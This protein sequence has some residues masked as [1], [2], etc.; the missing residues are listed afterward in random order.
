VIQPAA[1]E[2]PVSDATV[3]HSA[4]RLSRGAWWGLGF[5]WAL[6]LVALFMAVTLSQRVGNLQ[7]Q[8]ARQTADAM[9]TSVEARTLARHADEQ[10]QSTSAKVAALEGR[11]GD[12]MA[13]RDKMETLVQSVVRAR[14]ENVVVELEA[15]LRFA[16]D[17]AQLTGSPRPLLAALHTAEARLSQGVDPRLAP[18]SQA[19][20]RDLE[21]IQHARFPDTAGLLV[22]IDQVQRE[23][24]TL[25][26]GKARGG[27]GTSP[28]E[29]PA[30]PANASWWAR[31]RRSISN[32]FCRIVRCSGNV[33][34]LQALRPDQVMLIRQNLRL[35]LEGARLGLLARQYASSRT[36][37]EAAL[38]LV[39]NWFDPTSPRT[40]AVVK[41]LSESQDLVRAPDWPDVSDTLAALRKLE[42]TGND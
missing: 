31:V 14:D 12:L 41:T 17:Q 32:G 18:V 4:A 9:K 28:P 34:D 20:A 35:R 39:Q 10:V 36:D 37:L 6:A 1:P 38:V 8:L 29:Q 7:E 11:V 5:A 2:Q 27:A 13:Y 26:L 30:A 25:P 22:R 40:Q 16:Q 42:S 19:V 24:D 15:A 33:V 21:R 3:V 23:V